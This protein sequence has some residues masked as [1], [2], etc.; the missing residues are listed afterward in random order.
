M[1]RDLLRRMLERAGFSVVTA[2][3]GLQGLE[4]FRGGGVHVMITDMM[5]PEMDGL[6]LIRILRA[7]R[8]NLQVIAVSG[9]DDR[10]GYLRTALN[11]GAKA[12]LRKPVGSAELVQTVRRVLS[13]GP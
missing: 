8:P 2:V 9:A 1:M 10:D 11:L 6:E 7:E 3:D 13:A 12:V 4:R 5:M